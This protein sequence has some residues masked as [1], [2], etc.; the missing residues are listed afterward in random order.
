VKTT[1]NIIL[2]TVIIVSITYGAV[3]FFEEKSVAARWQKEA[4]RTYQEQLEAFNNWEISQKPITPESWVFRNLWFQAIIVFVQLTD[5][6]FSILGTLVPVTLLII[7]RKKQ[8][9]PV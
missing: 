2:Y 4:K 3:I 5:S 1:I 6:L 9:E 7:Q 8:K